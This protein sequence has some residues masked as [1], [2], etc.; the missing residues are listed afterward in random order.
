LGLSTLHQEDDAGRDK[1]AKARS[2]TRDE[3]MIMTPTE[4]NDVLETLYEAIEDAQRPDNCVYQS[5][6]DKAC[7]K[8][9]DI[10]LDEQSKIN[11]SPA[12][13]DTQGEK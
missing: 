9:K 10:I 8:L 1:D 5:D 7:Q 6:L 12:K 4:W 11:L 2:N 3:R 13:Q